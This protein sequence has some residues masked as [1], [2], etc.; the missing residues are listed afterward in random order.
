MRPKD[1]RIKDAGLLGALVGLLV[2]GPRGV[3]ALGL[4]SAAMQTMVEYPSESA[5][6]LRKILEPKKPAKLGE[7]Q[8]VAVSNP[9][10]N[11]D[12]ELKECRACGS[13]H[14]EPRC[15]GR[16]ARRISV[17]HGR[18]KRGNRK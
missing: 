4:S 17:R 10:T 6:T 14:R 5:V 12:V 8:T 3:L 18:R 2:N 7:P 9:P 13:F 1:E 15:Q 16:P 11:A